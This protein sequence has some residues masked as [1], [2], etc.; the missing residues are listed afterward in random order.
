MSEKF[1]YDSKT[2]RSLAETDFGQ[3][4]WEFLNEHDNIIR[5]Q[6][7]SYLRKPALAAIDELLKDRFGEKIQEDRAKQMCGN[8]VCQVM[9][10]N[11]YVLEKTGVLV[12]SGAGLFKSAARYKKGK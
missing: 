11:G 9:K 6:T 5:M 4:L 1:L 12:Y 2:F 3:K 10:R 8:M 7:A